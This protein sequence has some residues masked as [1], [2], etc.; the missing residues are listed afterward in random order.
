M[1]NKRRIANKITKARLDEYL[2]LVGWKTQ[3]HGANHFRLYNP[4]GGCSIFAFT[5][6]RDYPERPIYEIRID[7]FGP[8]K[9]FGDVPKDYDYVDGGF[10][11]FVLEGCTLE[12]NSDDGG[13]TWNFV[14]IMC[15]V[16]GKQTAFICF[17][18]WS[19][20]IPKDAKL[21]EER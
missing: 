9:P 20:V 8:Q 18:D 2:A 11:V 10:M 1:K 4:Y 3:H 6:D 12:A 17:T 19:D 14:S 21:E 16:K 13:K 5:A 15:K 7:G